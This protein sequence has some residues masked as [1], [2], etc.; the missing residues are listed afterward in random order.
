ME[1]SLTQTAALLPLL[2]ARLCVQ[3]PQLK[4]MDPKLKYEYSGQKIYIIFIY[5]V[6]GV[7]RTEYRH[8]LEHVAFTA[9]VELAR[10]AAHGFSQP[11]KG[12][13]GSRVP[14]VL[15]GPNP[16]LEKRI[17]ASHYLR[18]LCQFHTYKEVS[19]MFPHLMHIHTTDIYGQKK[20]LLFAEQNF[21]SRQS[22]CLVHWVL[23]THAE[24]GTV[25]FAFFSLPVSV[26]SIPASS[27][28]SWPILD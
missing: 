28:R 22:Y 27:L 8:F 2:A 15:P 23:F 13:Q 10:L 21:Q 20:K 25:I 16:P 6:K 11:Q 24:N 1:T 17:G 12:W 4:Q 14:P 18:K 7:F 9:W 26:Q 5:P 19:S 3:Q